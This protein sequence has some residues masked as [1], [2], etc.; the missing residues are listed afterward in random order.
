MNKVKSFILIMSLV[1]IASCD[2]ERIPES[3]LNDRAF[4]NDNQNFEEACNRLYTFLDGYAIVVLH[5]VRTDFSYFGSPN[6]ISSGSRLPSANSDDWT[7]PYRLV[8][9]ANKIIQQAEGKDKISKIKQWIGEARFFRAYAYFELVSKF[10]DVPLVLQP[11]DIDSEELYGGRTAREEVVQQI[12]SDLDYAA[13]HLPTFLQLGSADYGRVSKNAALAFKSRVALFEGTRQKFHSYGSPNEHLSKAASAAQS[14]MEMNEHSLYP[15][16]YLLF[17]KAGEGFSNKENILPSLYGVDATNVIRQHQIARRNKENSAT[18]Y[19]VDMFLCTDGLP[20][21]K[22][23][24]AVTPEMEPNP[25]Y[26]FRNKDTR[27]HSLLY[28]LGEPYRNTTFKWD[29]GDISTRYAQRKYL[30]NQDWVGKNGFVDIAM[31]RYGEVLLNYAEAKFELEGSISDDDLN[32]SINLLRARGSVAPLSNS[33]AATHGLDLRTEIRRERAVELA[34]EGFRY[35]DIMR[36][37]IAEDVLPR[38]I[39]GA[40][41]FQDAYPSLKAPISE[42]GYILLEKAEKRTFNPQRDYLYPIPVREVGF[43]L[44][45]NPN[46][47]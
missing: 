4:W 23:P 40:Y 17:Q 5:D 33:F 30:D 36:W 45:Q 3:N 21:D 19:L 43:G 39:L 9:T 38:D 8:F 25:W 13:E 32:K 34:S 29:N 37:K 46:W 22:S 42:D 2:L 20:M 14:L 28:K 41:Y 11:L 47:D 6:A 16:H 24:L 27:L 12:Y 10:G 44:E 35:N 15:D 26:I 1:F 7:V 18:K 31:I